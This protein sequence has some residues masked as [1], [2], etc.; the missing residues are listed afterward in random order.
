MCMY[1]YMY[2]YM[3]VY[4]IDR[5]SNKFS[6]L[7]SEP[8][9][10]GDSV[11]VPEG[12]AILLDEDSCTGFPIVVSHYCIMRLT[13]YFY[14]SRFFTF[15]LYYLLVFI[16]YPCERRARLNLRQGAKRS[17]PTASRKNNNV[18]VF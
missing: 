10:D 8:P 11:V 1:M 18:M 6:W 15:L 13:Y 12:Q 16:T 17:C 4:T 14:C 2:M 5:W 3:Y 7:H 9:V